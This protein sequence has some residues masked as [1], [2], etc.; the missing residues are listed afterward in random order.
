MSKFV[1]SLQLPNLVGKRIVPHT[2][3]KRGTRTAVTN[4]KHAVASG[5]WRSDGDR[6]LMMMT[7]PDSE[8]TSLRRKCRETRGRISR[9]N[10]QKQL[11]TSCAARGNEKITFSFCFAKV[12]LN[13]D[14]LQSKITHSVSSSRGCRGRCRVN[15]VQRTNKK[16]NFETNKRNAVL[17]KDLDQAEIFSR[18]AKKECSKV[19]RRSCF[20]TFLSMSMST[21]WRHAYFSHDVSIDVSI[22][23]LFKLDETRPY[24]RSKKQ[25]GITS[26]WH[27]GN[28]CSLAPG[29]APCIVSNADFTRNNPSCR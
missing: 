17:Q 20:C 24:N 19:G 22:D 29:H 25:N 9:G 12:N 3:N 1:K 18:G 11:T 13:V 28:R 16:Q 14:W 26:H 8:G 7:T 2:I 23:W 21:D 10:D 4:T 5:I 15:V 6:V 27:R